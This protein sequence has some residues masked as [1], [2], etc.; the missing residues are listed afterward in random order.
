ME[1][2]AVD[3]RDLILK[4]LEEM[5]RG[6]SWL[7]KKTDIPYATLYD[8][9]IKKGFNISLMNLYKINEV[10]GTNFK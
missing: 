9:L 4:K 6:I 3:T 1:V 10:L 5:E 2:N 7:G 8:C